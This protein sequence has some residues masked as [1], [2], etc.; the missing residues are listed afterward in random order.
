MD[1]APTVAERVRRRLDA[2]RRADGVDTRGD[3]LARIVHWA[4][5]ALTFAA[6]LVMS[7]HQ[8]FVQDDWVFAAKASENGL[9][10][11]IR[12]YDIHWVSA[13]LAGFRVFFGLFGFKRYLPYLV[14]VLLLHVLAGHLLWR[15]MRQVGVNDWV[16]TAAAGSFLACATGP[17][18]YLLAIETGGTGSLVL[19]LA[20]L[21]LVNHGG[22]E[23]RRDRLAIA[24]AVLSLPFSGVSP[25][26]IGVALLVVALRRGWRAGLRFVAVP[27]GVYVVWFLLFARGGSSGKPSPGALLKIPFFIWSG[28]LATIDKSTVFEG[29]GVLAVVALAAW[30]VRHWDLRGTRAAPAFAMAAG[31]VAFFVIV[32]PARVA[33]FARTGD[34]EGRYVYFTWP[35]LVPLI[36]LAVTSLFDGWR[37]R[38]AAVVGLGLVSAV[39]GF[40]GVLDETR[41]EE[42]R[43]AVLR[44]R[45]LSSARVVTTESFLPDVLIDDDSAPSLTASRLQRFQRLGDLPSLPSLTPEQ[46]GR[47]ALPLQARFVGSAP[48]GVTGAPALGAV[49]GAT[50]A[51]TPDG[52]CTRI[53]PGD[54]GRPQ[55]TLAVTERSVLRLRSERGGEATVVR[56]AGDD[57]GAAATADYDLGPGRDA[58]LELVPTGGGWA[59][60]LP[61]D[62]PTLVC[63]R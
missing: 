3:Q 52:D 63:R 22:D 35:L 24:V 46:F 53:T 25:I 50:S 30:S 21:L 7:R 26:L 37:W 49:T 19:G 17:V 20:L 8:W 54:E 23:P 47:A 11:I 55:L 10:E 40:S 31:V 39:H 62:S 4:S 12:A 43:E 45:V 5:L 9:G 60:L 6:L 57:P 44:S 38:E 2:P 59:V 61:A 18:I 1:P 13:P 36:G 42:Q 16:A 58:F 41:S 29:A 34:I 48:A 28:L 27:A 56:G 33:T 32:G 14:P 15:L 51:G